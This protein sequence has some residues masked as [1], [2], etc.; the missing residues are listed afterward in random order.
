MST[1]TDRILVTGSWSWQN[2]HAV[3]AT[4]WSFWF[5][6]GRRT[7]IELV[8]GDCP[9][10]GADL[11]ADAFWRAQGFP[12]QKMPADFAGLGRKAGPL[13]NQQMIELGGYLAAF[14]FP[15]PGSKGTVDCI[16]RIRKAGIPLTII[17]D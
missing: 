17:T 8:H 16:D 15:L 1:K 6:N 12:V 14:A 7:D 2:A 4:L 11:I 3:E 13:R 9:Y 5:Q 10:G